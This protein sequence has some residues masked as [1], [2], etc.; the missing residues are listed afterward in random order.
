MYFLFFWQVEFDWNEWVEELEPYINDNDWIDEDTES[1]VKN[2]KHY[3][4]KKRFDDFT[5]SRA[6]KKI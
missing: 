3:K 2:V 1:N 4:V 5:K 6:N